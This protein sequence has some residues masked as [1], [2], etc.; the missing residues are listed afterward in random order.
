MIRILTLLIIVVA[1]IQIPNVDAHS[2]FNSAEQSIGNN[3]VQIGTLPEFPNIGETSQI[4]I[5]ITDKDYE[6]VEKFIIGI[7][8]FYNNQQID[9]IGPYSIDGAHVEFD[10]IF[11][12]SGNHIFEVDLHDAGNNGEIITY[13]FNLST[14]SPF[15]YIFFA[16]I[17][18]GSLMLL[19]VLLYI[20]LSKWQ[21]NRS[22]SST[23]FTR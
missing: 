17:I 1:L 7:R 18:T 22:N 13:S 6:E 9:T 19:A 23:R 12:I 4:V 3:R 21:K 20:Y 15:G 2:L 16:A 10:Y 8:I 14:Q 5:R 11:E